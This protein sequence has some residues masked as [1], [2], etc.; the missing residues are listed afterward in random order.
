MSR[1]IDPAERKAFGMHEAAAEEDRD[2]GRAGAHVDHRRAKIGLVVGKDGKAGDVG[3]CHHGLDVE[4]AALD[5]EHQLRAAAMSVVATCMSTPKR[6]PSMPR[7]S[8]MP[9]PPSIE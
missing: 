6:A 1:D 8:R 9:L 5:R 3:T 7:G 4:V 2:G